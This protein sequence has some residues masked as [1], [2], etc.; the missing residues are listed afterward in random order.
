MRKSAKAVIRLSVA[1]GNILDYL[2]CDSQVD[3]GEYLV[4][5]ACGSSSV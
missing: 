1:R 5:F 2:D 3:S 4:Y